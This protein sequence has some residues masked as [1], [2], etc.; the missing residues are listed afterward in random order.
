MAIADILMKNNVH[1]NK[2]L[3]TDLCNYFQDD[4]AKFDP[5]RFREHLDA[6]PF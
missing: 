2:Q 5:D 6:I 4:N 1:S 3:V